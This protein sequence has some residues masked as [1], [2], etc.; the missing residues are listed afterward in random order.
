MN[1]TFEICGISVPRIGFGTLFV[2]E[3]RGFGPARPNSVGLL[4]EAA[5]LGVRFFDTADSYGNGSAEDALRRALHPYDGLVIATKGGFRHERPGSWVADGR[6][7]HLR[8]ALEGSLK[9]L[10]VETIA[11]Y[12]LHAPDSDVPY[13]DSVGALAGLQEEGK[14][15]EIG[16]SNV[17]AR[18]L[19]VARREA[20]IVSVQNAY[21]IRYRAD[22]DVLEICAKDGIAFIPWSPLSDGT[23]AT[24]DREI[25]RI[26]KKHAATSAQVALAALLHRSEVVLPIPGTSSSAHLKEN[27]AAA[28]VA[29]DAEDLAALWG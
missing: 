10:A 5:S 7:A 25:A 23:L 6:P 20:R 13:A 17:D 3:S 21:N 2:P 19:A 24:R 16:V 9:R 14:I 28:K 1:T 15:R 27:V 8:A 12:Q 11:L 26:A 22:D 18:E 4:R 29:L